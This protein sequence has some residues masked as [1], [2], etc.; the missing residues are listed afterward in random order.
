[1]LS[2]GTV[3]A[4]SLRDHIDPYLHIKIRR[5]RL[6]LP[7]EREPVHPESSFNNS[8]RTCGVRAVGPCRHRWNITGTSLPLFW[9]GVS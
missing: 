7:L 3:D 4:M 9:R 1:V 8:G 5:C 6:P 2:P